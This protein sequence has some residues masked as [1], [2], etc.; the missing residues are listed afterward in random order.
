M[1]LTGTASAMTN[2]SQVKQFS[3]G[4]GSQPGATDPEALCYS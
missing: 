3:L 4:Y 2:D 1:L